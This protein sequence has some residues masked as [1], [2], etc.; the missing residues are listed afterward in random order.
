MEPARQPNTFI[1]QDPALDAFADRITS[2]LSKTDRVIS[3][4]DPIIREGHAS[5]NPSIRNLCKEL[6]HTHF[7][8]LRHVF[9]MDV[10]YPEVS[11][12]HNASAPPSLEPNGLT[13]SYD[14]FTKKDFPSML[15]RAQLT[16]G[17]V[18]TADACSITF[19]WDPKYT[20]TT[21]VTAFHGTY[22]ALEKMIKDAAVLRRQE[23][24]G[25]SRPA[26]PPSSIYYKSF[27]PGEMVSA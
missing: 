3:S 25:A 22:T 23:L 13:I 11:A 10:L 17:K 9:V 20:A 19:Q 7:A 14:T 12:I 5:E 27:A 8:N 26:A 18:G 15:A 16:R 24:A 6:L 21:R 1:S 4:E 2:Y